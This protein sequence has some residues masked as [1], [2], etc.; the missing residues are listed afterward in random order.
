MGTAVTKCG[1]HSAYDDI[2]AETLSIVVIISYEE[3]KGA[4][5]VSLC[6]H[7]NCTMREEMEEGMKEGREKEGP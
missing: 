3:R 5:S 7:S 1:F 4:V 6:E 2:I